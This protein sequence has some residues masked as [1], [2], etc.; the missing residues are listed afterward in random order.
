MMWR[1][2]LVDRRFMGSMISI[3]EDVFISAGVKGM[4]G[5]LLL[6]SYFRSIQSP[7]KL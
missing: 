3:E 5:V 6:M 2:C 1:H 7:R 4:E